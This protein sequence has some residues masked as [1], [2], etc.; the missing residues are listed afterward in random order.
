M[1]N[2]I[3]VSNISINPASE[4]LSNFATMVNSIKIVS[5][6]SIDAALQFLID[7]PLQFLNAAQEFLS[8]FATTVN[9]KKMFQ[10]DEADLDRSSSVDSSSSPSLL[11]QQSHT[12]ES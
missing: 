2:R 12:N 5:K 11:T 9:R 10:T 1:V 4:F 6:R 7:A 8:N 3:I